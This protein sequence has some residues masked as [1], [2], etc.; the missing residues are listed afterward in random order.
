LFAIT[1]FAVF[2]IAPG[3]GNDLIGFAGHV[4]SAEY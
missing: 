3:F 2:F 1:F 4:C